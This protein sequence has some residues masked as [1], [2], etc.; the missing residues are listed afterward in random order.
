ME[1]NLLKLNG[2]RN[3]K[4]GFYEKDGPFARS[5]PKFKRNFEF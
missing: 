5:R 3:F 4:T 2:L 1:F